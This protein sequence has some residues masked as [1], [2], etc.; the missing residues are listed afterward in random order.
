MAPVVVTLRVYDVGKVPALIQ[1]NHLLRAVGTGAFHAAVEV[2][3]TEYSYGYTDE[4][5]GVFGCWPAEAEQVYEFRE[6][7]DMGHTSLT[8]DA[9]MELLGDMSDE[10]P[11]DAYDLLR[12]N[13][14]HFSDALC[15][16]LGL[17]GI[18]GDELHTCRRDELA[19]V[20]LLG[21]FNHVLHCMQHP[22]RQDLHGRHAGG[23][24]V[25]LAGQG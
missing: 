22:T 24:G 4:G 23:P 7:I 5:S 8:E 10:W 11:G 25:G 13:C 2:F 17:G 9:L 6:A 1:A 12:R 14:T 3:G 20:V 16:R 21:E 18:P 19:A 15:R